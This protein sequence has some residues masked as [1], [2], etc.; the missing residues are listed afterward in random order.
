MDQRQEIL[1]A[2]DRLC[3]TL[4]A[5]DFFGHL[6]F[7]QHGSG[8]FLIFK[9][10]GCT[11]EYPSWVIYDQPLQADWV[12][13]EEGVKEMNN[14]LERIPSEK[15]KHGEFYTYR[16]VLDALKELND[17]QLDMTAMIYDPNTKESFAVS[18]CFVVSNLPEEHYNEVELEDEQPLLVIG[19]VEGVS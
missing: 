3:K 17:E 1:S 11:G 2:F 5:D 13:L 7:G 8:K 19:P 9:C 16:H 15:P 10:R 6:E 4:N 12:S 14:L 18:E